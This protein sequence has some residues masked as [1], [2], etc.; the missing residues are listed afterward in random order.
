VAWIESWTCNPKIVGSS[1]STG[2]KCGSV[3]FNSA[4]LLKVTDINQDGHT[5]HTQLNYSNSGLFHSYT[6]THTAQ[7]AHHVQYYTVMSYA[8]EN[9]WEN[10]GWATDPCIH[11]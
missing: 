8:N 11:S 6:H 7:N 4:V 9:K 10:I 5:T 3:L 2:S 1:L